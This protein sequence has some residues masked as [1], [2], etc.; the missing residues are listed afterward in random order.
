[1]ERRSEPVDPAQPD[2]GING[3][4]DLGIGFQLR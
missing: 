2:M 3:E 1:M 4:S